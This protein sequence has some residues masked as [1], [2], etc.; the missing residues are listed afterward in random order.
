MRELPRGLAV[1]FVVVVLMSAP[2]TRAC[3]QP[4]GVPKP[5]ALAERT[6]PCKKSET[7]IAS[8]MRTKERRDFLSL[9]PIPST[10]GTLPR[11]GVAGA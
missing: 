7:T 2:S 10:V 1:V 6:P 4:A 9:Q 3:P 5:G 11:R 8:M